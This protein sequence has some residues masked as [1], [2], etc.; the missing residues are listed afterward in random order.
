MELPYILFSSVESMVSM[1]L[2]TVSNVSKKLTE[3]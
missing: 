1:N 2:D 3:S